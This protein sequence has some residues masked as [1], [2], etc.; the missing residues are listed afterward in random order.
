MVK[1]FNLAPSKKIHTMKKIAIVIFLFL[2]TSSYLV[3]AQSS[4]DAGVI[5]MPQFTGLLNIQDFAAGKELNYKLTSGFAGGL[6]GAYNFNKHI[7]VELNL[8]LS[9]QGEN[10]N[11]NLS[12]YKG[13]GADTASYAR[14]ISEQAALE[15]VIPGTA[16]DTAFT[17]KISLT[18]LKIPILFKL[19]SNTDKSVFFYL[20]A[21]PEFNIL[22]SASESLNGNTVSY[23]S[24]NPTFSFTTKQLFES[25]GVDV[26]LNLGVGINLT[27]NLILTA[28][29]NLD[30]GLTDAEDKSFEFPVSELGLSTQI[31]PYAANRSSNN[32]GTAGL[33]LGLAYK[34]GGSDSK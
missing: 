12:Y 25:S 23:T 3:K 10:Y 27:K 19:T 4:V 28:Q 24:T 5:I 22:L 6:S 21:G 16:A 1:I 9:K 18:Y 13:T 20:N 15:N 2:S 26:V 30:Y 31:H 11:G 7:G 14:L 34:F 8:L 32:N 29:V 17:A 33:R